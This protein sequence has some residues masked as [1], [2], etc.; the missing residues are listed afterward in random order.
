MEKLRWLIIGV[1]LFLVVAIDFTGRLMS[2]LADGMLVAGVIAV[3]LPML[4]KS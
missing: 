1:L 4:K 2:M 3:A